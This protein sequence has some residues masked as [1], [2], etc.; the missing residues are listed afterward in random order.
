MK[1][2]KFNVWC[3]ILIMVLQIAL[4][5]LS[6][7]IENAFSVISVAAA[8]EAEE[9]TEGDYKY[10]VDEGG[11]AAITDYTGNATE[12]EIPSTLGGHVV[13]IIESSTFYNR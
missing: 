12:I 6:V 9:F 7:T 3:L 4:P 2:K 1:I 13:T 11:N 8:E 10:T 5:I